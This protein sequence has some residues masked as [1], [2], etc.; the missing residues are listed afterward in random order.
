MRLSDV[1]TPCSCFSKV[2]NRGGGGGRKEKEAK[3]PEENNWIT[4][5]RGEKKNRG[6]ILTWGD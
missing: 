2:Q 5:E 6:T 4:G 3:H 1:A